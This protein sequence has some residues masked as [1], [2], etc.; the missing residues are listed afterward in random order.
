MTFLPESDRAY[1]SEKA[2]NYREVTDNGQK[3]LILCDYVLPTKKFDRDNAD[4]LI[5]LPQGYSDIQPDMFYLYPGI[6][7]MPDKSPVTKTQ[8]NITFE[9]KEWQRW[10]RH[11]PKNDWRPG[12]DGI[13]TYLKKID[14]ALNNAKTG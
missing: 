4:L 7:L 10:S 2:L 13:H 14:A 11:S 1:L 9:K 8:V 5:L 6:F 12:I 3:G